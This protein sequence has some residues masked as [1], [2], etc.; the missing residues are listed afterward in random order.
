[1]LKVIIFCSELCEWRRHRGQPRVRHEAGSFPE[2]P[3]LRLDSTVAR[4]VLGWRPPLGIEQALRLTAE[5]YRDYYAQ[6]ASAQPLT[7]GQIDHY[8]RLVASTR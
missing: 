3:F 1:M 8:R 7:M 6:P 5:W 4:D 2:T